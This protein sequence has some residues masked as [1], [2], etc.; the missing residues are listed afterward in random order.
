MSETLVEQESSLIQG[1]ST[2]V[3]HLPVGWISLQQS[4]GVAETDKGPHQTSAAWTLSLYVQLEFY[5]RSLESC[6]K[7][8]HR[9]SRRK[10][11]ESDACP[12]RLRNRH[13]KS[14]VRRY[15]RRQGE[16]ASALFDMGVINDIKRFHLV[17]EAIDRIP[18]LDARAT[19]RATT[20]T[21]PTLRTEH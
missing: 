5:L 7:E 11:G 6:P 9:P 13:R 12:S 10:E 1:R 15:R 20:M 2:A 21:C 8:A 16:T 18:H 4:A 3:N 17:A 19:D 14:R